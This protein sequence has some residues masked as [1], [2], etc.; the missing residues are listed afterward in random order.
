[1]LTIEPF[2]VT[3][4]SLVANRLERFCGRSGIFVRSFLKNLILHYLHLNITRDVFV[5]TMLLGSSN[6]VVEECIEINSVRA[7]SNFSNLSVSSCQLRGCRAR[8]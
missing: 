5:L 2:F 4:C 7:V 6:D 8:F 1:M 3:D